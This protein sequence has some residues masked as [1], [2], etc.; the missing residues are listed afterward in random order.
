[1]AIW[2]MLPASF[3]LLWSAFIH[4]HWIDPP[5]LAMNGWIVP[6][7]LAASA[8]VA[9][10]VML[11]HNRSVTYHQRIRNAWSQVDVDLKMRYDLVPQ[12]VEVIKGFRQHEQELQSALAALRQG[13][14]AAGQRSTQELAESLTNMDQQ[15][16]TLVA[17]CE[18]YPQLKTDLLHR[19]LFDQVT[20][21]EEKIAHG[22][23]VFNEAV[24]EFNGLVLSFPAGLLFRFQAHP[25]WSEEQES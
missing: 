5:R 22:R 16:H 2:L 21:L 1:M 10:V 6:L 25:F 17:V 3:T 19:Q 24:R 20:A 8:T 15:F 7:L 12:I 11:I 9:Y 23:L 18:Q 14:P 13:S 4:L